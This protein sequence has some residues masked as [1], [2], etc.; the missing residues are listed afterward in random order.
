MKTGGK[1]TVP[2]PF[3]FNLLKLHIPAAAIPGSELP[4][5]A[6]SGRIYALSHQ[7]DRETDG[8]FLIVLF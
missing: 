1:Q 3:W 6:T 8:V 5:P 7:E 2:S 4:T